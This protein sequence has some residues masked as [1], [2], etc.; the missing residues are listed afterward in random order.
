M[1]QQRHQNLSRLRRVIQRRQ[2]VDVLFLEAEKAR[3]WDPGSL[4][5]AIGPTESGVSL[6][7]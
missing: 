6:L 3:E 1:P 4:L 2:I 5:V 7:A